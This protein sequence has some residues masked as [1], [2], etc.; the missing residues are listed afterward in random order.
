M[1]VLS[2]GDDTSRELAEGVSV[3]FGSFLDPLGE[4]VAMPVVTGYGMSVME[5]M[6]VVGQYVSGMSSC[7]IWYG[8]CIF[9]IEPK[10]QHHVQQ[11]YVLLR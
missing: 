4:T 11:N 7:M 5:T 9:L 10:E 6:C 1:T 2:E 3:V 8:L